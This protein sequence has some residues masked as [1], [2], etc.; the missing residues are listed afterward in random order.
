MSYVLSKQYM[1]MDNHHISPKKDNEKMHCFIVLQILNVMQWKNVNT[2]LWKKIVFKKKGNIISIWKRWLGDPGFPIIHG[3]CTW[4]PISNLRTVVEGAGNNS[5]WLYYSDE[6]PSS[7]K[8]RLWLWKVFKHLK[9]EQIPG[10]HRQKEDLGPPGRREMHRVPAFLLVR[11]T[12][13]T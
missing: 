6:I 4:Y 11:A 13:R 9:E 12:V 10:S 8:W 1:S 7:K 3:C 2:H 5:A